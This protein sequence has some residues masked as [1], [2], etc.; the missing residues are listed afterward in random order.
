MV[1]RGEARSEFA[2]IKAMLTRQAR[3]FKL[4]LD[5]ANNREAVEVLK[6]KEP[7]LKPYTD[8]YKVCSSVSTCE[9]LTDNLGF[10]A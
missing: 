1:S 7:S 8:S 2:N 4:M 3:H 10:T 9:E 6:I 5:G